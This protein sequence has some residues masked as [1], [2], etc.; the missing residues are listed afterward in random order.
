MQL[1]LPVSGCGTNAS[2][3]VSSNLFSARALTPQH[4][5]MERRLRIYPGDLELG[6][7]S[8][9]RFERGDSAERTVQHRIVYPATEFCEERDS[10]DE[11]H[12]V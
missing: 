3:R 7:F 11:G 12:A 2:V 5:S 6:P 1:I 10:A 4:F 9:P 8:C